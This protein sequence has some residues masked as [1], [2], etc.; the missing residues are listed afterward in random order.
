M[1][2]QEKFEIFTCVFEIETTHGTTRQVID[3]PRIMIE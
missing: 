1:T 2:I 3:A